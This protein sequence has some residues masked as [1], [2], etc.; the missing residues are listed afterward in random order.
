MK[1]FNRIRILWKPFLAILAIF[2]AAAACTGSNSA[3]PSP[4]PNEVGT[5]VAATMEA[6][7][8]QAT[9]PSLPPTVAPSPT[10]ALQPPTPVLPAA[11]RINFL[12]D[13]TASVVT[14]TIQASQCLYYV[15]N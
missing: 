7:Q 8:A 14:G 13:A 1:P 6:I 10:T 2:I 12:T 15:L 11:T 9:P 5:V 4:S 3:I